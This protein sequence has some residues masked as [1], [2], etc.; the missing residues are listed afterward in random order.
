[1]YSLWGLLSQ[2]L[3]LRMSTMMS[4]PITNDDLL[5]GTFT[6]FRVGSLTQVL[7]SVRLSIVAFRQADIIHYFLDCAK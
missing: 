3:I 5:V 1:M 2:L 6:N 4:S 7:V